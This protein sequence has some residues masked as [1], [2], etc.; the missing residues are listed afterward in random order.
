M[1]E[2]ELKELKE[3][4]KVIKSAA[5]L[6]YELS[7]YSGLDTDRMLELIRLKIEILGL[8]NDIKRLS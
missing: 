2:L 3:L 6:I 5:S 7:E 1:N 4:K 8:K